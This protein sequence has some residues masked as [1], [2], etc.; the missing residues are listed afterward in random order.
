M[1]DQLDAATISDFIVYQLFL[2]MFRGVFT[3]IIRRSDCVFT[4]YG[5]LSCCSCCDVFLPVLQP[6]LP[7]SV[8]INTGSLYRNVSILN[9]K[10]DKDNVS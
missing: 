2:N 7:L 10:R 1:R 5:F 4:A 3:P 6:T 9:Y 8:R